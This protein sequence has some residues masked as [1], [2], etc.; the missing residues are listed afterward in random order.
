MS[1]GG[2]YSPQ[3]GGAIPSMHLRTAARP[4]H[5]VPDSPGGPTL[6]KPSIVSACLQFLYTAWGRGRIP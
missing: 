2:G 3:R 5:M 1:G 6:T 4:L